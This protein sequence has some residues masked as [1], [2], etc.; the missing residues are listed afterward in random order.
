VL[1]DVHN[2]V[3]PAEALDLLGREPGYGVAIEGDRWVAGHHVP[4]TIA[5]A[6]RDPSAKIAEMDENG[7][8]VAVVSSPPPLFFYDV[9]SDL[10]ATF[11]ET[12]NDGM[13]KFCSAHPGRMRW[14]ANLPLQD[15]ARAVEVYAT[16]VARG[17]VGAAIGTS[18]AGRRLDEPAFET[19]WAAAEETGRPVL[20]HPAF[21]EPHSALAPYYLQ[22][23]IGNP[24]ETTIMIERM[25]CAGVFARHPELRL[26]V[27]HGGG[28]LPY[29]VGR[30]AHACGVRP[31][32]Q[33]SADEV[34]RV[35][36]QLYFDT[37]THD[38]AP[39]RYLAELVGIDHVL[40]GTDLPFDMAQRAPGAVLA[41]AFNADEQRR[42]GADNAARLFALN[43][44]AG[45]ATS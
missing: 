42:I 6:F 3:M 8:D 28:Y 36:G 41:E 39:L 12:A 9:A 10:A 40:V 14:L 24:L 20:V 21:N 18:V 16:A 32:I 2:H 15:P 11:C 17:C 37:I 26:I 45:K 29:Q 19:F 5:A 43:G 34:W 22:N 33:V 27:M 7:I 31:E 38:A 23:V 30:L 25:I 4:F 35:F 44:I 13:A 1:I